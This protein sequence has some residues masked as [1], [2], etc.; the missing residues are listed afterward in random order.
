MGLHFHSWSEDE[1]IYFLPFLDIHFR[2]KYITFGWGIWRVEIH[3]A[4]V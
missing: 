1:A 3:Y 2:W 4:D